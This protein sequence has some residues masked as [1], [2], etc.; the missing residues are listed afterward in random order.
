MWKVKEDIDMQLLESCGY[1]KFEFDNVAYKP[2]DPPM[3]ISWVKQVNKKR[4]IQWYG[5]FIINGEIELRRCY[6]HYYVVVK[7]IRR[8]Y[9]Q[10]LIDAGIVE[11]VVD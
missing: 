3:Y 2:I 10:P 1:E 9:I 4:N 8:K 11:K 7:R 5:V 6:L